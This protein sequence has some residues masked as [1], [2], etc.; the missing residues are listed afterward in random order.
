MRKRKFRFQWSLLILLFATIYFYAFAGWSLYRGIANYN[1]QK[2]LLSVCKLKIKATE[3]DRSYSEKGDR[4][5]ETIQY[6]YELEG[7]KYTFRDRHTTTQNV[8]IGRSY[9]MNKEY[10]HGTIDIYV[11]PD[12]YEEWFRPG[13][14]ESAKF[15]LTVPI[16]LFFLGS[17]FLGLFLLLGFRKPFDVEA[18]MEK[19][20][21]QKAKQEQKAGLNLS[22]TPNP[23]KPFKIRYI[24][25]AIAIVSLI[26]SINMVIYAIKTQV[27]RVRNE[28]TCILEVTATLEDSTSGRRGPNQRK[29]TGIYVSEDGDTYKYTVYT[30]WFNVYKFPDT[31]TFMVNPTDH[32]DYYIAV[33]SPM[34]LG[35]TLF[36]PCF[37]IVVS[38]IIILIILAMNKSDTNKQSKDDTV[39]TSC[40]EEQSH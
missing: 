3:T 11:N 36:V 15:K 13:G 28:N 22:S 6:E 37:Y 38:I 5:Y 10:T 31:K 2:Y 24:V 27:D 9:Y 19:E 32:A 12:N 23:K 14:M 40:Y 29:N 1:H 35:L 16:L 30:G 17:I 4:Y 8:Y 25:L 39:W 34:S 26:G 20:R 33:D 18:M 21:Q 7:K